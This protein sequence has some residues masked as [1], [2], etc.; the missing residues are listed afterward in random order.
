[1]EALRWISEINQFTVGLKDVRHHNGH[2]CKVTSE[3][4][5]AENDSPRLLGGFEMELRDKAV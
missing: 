4:R 3:M 5:A 2:H 1:L